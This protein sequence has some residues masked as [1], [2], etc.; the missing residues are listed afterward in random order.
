MPPTPVK[1]TSGL[2]SQ[3]VFER[4]ED[5]IVSRVRPPGSRLIEDTIAAELGVSRTPVREALRM[6]HRAGWLDLHPHAG[7]Y[8]RQPSLEEVRDVFA[9]REVLESEAGR[10][11]AHR[12][13]ETHLR[14]L[15]KILERGNRAIARG[16]ARAVVSLNTDFHG[17]IANAAD[18]LLLTRFLT[19]IAKQVQWHFVAVASA[20]RVD[21]W[22]EHA[23]IYEAI[24]NRD[25]DLAARLSA[26]HS[27]ATQ[28]LYIEQFLRPVGV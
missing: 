27:R 13:D 9:M 26:E 23:G 16:D 4:L 5:E 12:A 17:T 19:E 25:A 10:L 20:R 7:A 8:V 21:S 1:R 3:E 11:A 18:N 28:Q 15:Q 24:A 14:E 2:R 6:L 22:R